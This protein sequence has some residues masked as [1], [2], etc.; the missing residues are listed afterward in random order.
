M[1]HVQ[2]Q[3][4]GLNVSFT[5]RTVLC[6]EV[7]FHD[8][9][10]AC[11]HKSHTRTSRSHA[12]PWQRGISHLRGVKTTGV[13]QCKQNGHVPH[14]LALEPLVDIL[15]PESSLTSKSGFK[16]QSSVVSQM[17][18]ATNILQNPVSIN[19]T[20]YEY[21]LTLEKELRT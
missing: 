18:F 12:Q 3:Q 13:T 15:K 20:A 2:L 1:G 8:N 21:G 5:Q 11:A 17:T 16:V 7:T 9:L 4:Y 6:M 10:V 19:N 14:V